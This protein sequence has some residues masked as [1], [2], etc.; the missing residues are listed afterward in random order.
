MLTI[1]SFFLGDRIY[2][3]NGTMNLYEMLHEKKK[4]KLHQEKITEKLLRTGI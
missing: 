3:V 2:F 1:S 4:R